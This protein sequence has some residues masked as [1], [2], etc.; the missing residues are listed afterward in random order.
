MKE[1]EL[2]IDESGNFEQEN[3]QD[4]SRFP[5]LVGGVLLEK[6]T[7]SDKEITALVNGDALDSKEPPH[8]MN[9]DKHE[10]EKVVLPA[11]EMIVKRGGKLVYFEN[12]QRIDIY[13]NRE[14]YLRLLATGLIKLFS[15]LGVD[16]PFLIDITIAVRYSK[17]EIDDELSKI[18]DDEY[19]RT[20]RYYIKNGWKERSFDIDNDCRINLAILS[21]RSE[22][23][24]QLADYACNSRITRKSKQFGAAAKKRLEVLF[25]SGY[26]FDFNILTSENIII[27]ALDKSNISDAMMEY[28]TG[29][30]DI[31]KT[32]MHKLIYERL[33]NSSYRIAHLQLRSFANSLID[34]VRVDDDFEFDERIIK[35]VIKDLNNS[36]KNNGINI[37]S[38]ELFMKLYLYLA[39]RY[40]KEGDVIHAGPVIKEMKELLDTM[41]Y[42][43][44]NLVYLYL[45]NEK[46]ALYEIKCMDYKAAVDTMNITI[47][48]IENLISVLDLDK[49][50]SEFIND[51]DDFKSEYLGDAYCMK[52]YA[53]MFLQRFDKGLYDRCLRDDTDKALAQYE[54]EGELERNQQ[55]R[56]HVEME[57]G[58]YF[59]AL[60][61]L[62]KTKGINLQTENEIYDKAYRYLD[63][64]ESE[65]N[66]SKAFYMM[67]YVEIMLESFKGGKNDM[68]LALEKA[69]MVQ[70]SM[71][72]TFLSDR[73]YETDIKS[74][75]VKEPHIYENFM[76]TV[77]GNKP[78][79]Y[80]PL[81]I[82]LW[83]YGCYLA[84][85][86][87]K[88]AVDYYDRAIKIC[89]DNKD[90]TALKLIALAINMDKVSFWIETSKKRTEIVKF[91]QKQKEEI[92]D[93]LILELP[94]KMR[95]FL[96]DAEK[97]IQK[98]IDSGFDELG[99]DDLVKSS[100]HDISKRIAY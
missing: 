28:Y 91:L 58:N 78:I 94:E 8:A 2:W 60:R 76:W 3:E 7:F 12:R 55:Y 96:V 56:A 4:T 1:Y 75:K 73:P 50:I 97:S 61:W 99:D 69:I 18:T 93:L 40:I 9:M 67:Y 17:S 19:V 15:V 21:A 85:N 44:E 66:R 22:R 52:I 5:S 72:E 46:K 90:Y 48:C 83:K 16:G 63:E 42:K 35:E 33:A 47:K 86:S 30:G 31:D 92:M 27:S 100:L 87:K 38:D 74:D 82:I 54:Y 81:E 34:M 25:D 51:Q 62:F 36:F 80:H 64:A 70:K 89:N 68:A 41:N 53:E 45:F 37:Q 95:I 26:I 6:N 39:D 23:R 79:E 77:L 14:L 24:L 98:A 20:L 29:R 10:K 71:Y 49:S 65:D 84:L 88:K 57:Q 13:T 59:D 11:L 32:R 43:V